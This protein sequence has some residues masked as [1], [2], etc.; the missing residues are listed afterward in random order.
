MTSRLASL[1]LTSVCA[2]VF[3]AGGAVAGVAIAAP[4]M[5]PLRGSAGPQGQQGQQGQQGP[6]GLTGLTGATGATTTAAWGQCPYGQTKAT[7]A[8]Y[9]P[10]AVIGDPVWT[11]QV[12]VLR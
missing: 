3:G 9:V 4:H 5:T 12:C 7:V 8:T 1:A 2:L 10:G 11:A 6:Q